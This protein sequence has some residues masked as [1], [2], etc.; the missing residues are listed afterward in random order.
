MI[1]ASK[2]ESIRN[3][4]IHSKA[5]RFGIFTGFTIIFLGVMFLSFQAYMKDR[6]FPFVKVQDVSVGGLKSADALAKLETYYP[7]SKSLIFTLNGEKKDIPADKI[8]AKIDLSTAVT[9]A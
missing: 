8:D 1:E 6:I 9:Q 4:K 2:K 5:V 7:S 3:P